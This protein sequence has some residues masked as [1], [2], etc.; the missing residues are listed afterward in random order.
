MLSH[1]LQGAICLSLIACASAH[2]ALQNPP[3]WFDANGTIGMR[4][5]SQ[6]S[7]GCDL[8]PQ[9][10]S[11]C[12]CSW[13]TNYTFH[14]G[15]ATLPADMRTYQDVDG[16]D[17][18]VSM[19]WRAPGTAPVHSPCGVA[20]GNPTGCPPGSDDGTECPYGGYGYG[21][22]ARDLPF[23]KVVSTEWKVGS[24]VEVAWGIV[25]NHGG[26]YSYRLCK[27]GGELTEE[28]FQK[29]PLGF[30]GDSSWIQYGTN[31][32]NRTEIK[33]LRTTEG[34][35]PKGSQWTKVP[36]P[37]CAGSGGGFQSG[38]QQCVDGTQ[39][40]PPAPGILGFGTWIEGFPTYFDW[41][42]VDKLQVP[43]D[44]PPGDYVL[45]F[46]WDVEQ[47]AQVWNTCADI[48]IVA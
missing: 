22:D 46:R 44:L 3:S 28:C 20:G 45:S 32:A 35:F 47:T 40:P 16:Q 29:I 13:F 34:T 36:V 15:E 30:A 10:Q 43:Q 42:I 5:G 9:D 37:A 18:T 11:Y 33:A 31:P 38:D 4:A 7:P 6:C 1:F 26:G 24:N 25:A 21:P 14:T 48:K 27:L 23:E 8:S 19:P 17:W 12:S 2:G 41:S 39:Y